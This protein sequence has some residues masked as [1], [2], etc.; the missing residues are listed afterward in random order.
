LPP[1]GGDAALD[2]HFQ[3]RARLVAALRANQSPWEVQAAFREL[4]S[5]QVMERVGIYTDAEAWISDVLR[6]NGGPSA[7]LELAIAHFGWE[8]RR[9]V[10]KD[11]GAEMLALREFLKQEAEAGAFLA[12]LRD[13][14][15]EFHAALKEA[16]RPRTWSGNLLSFPKMELMRRFLDYV[17]DKAPHAENELD[18]QTVAWWRKRIRFWSRP[19]WMAGIVFRGVVIAFIVAMFAAGADSK[20]MGVAEARRRCTAA[21]ENVASGDAPCRRALELAPDSLLMRQYAGI[22]ALR[23]GDFARARS[24]FEQI[25]SLSPLDPVARY[26]LGLAHIG[27]LD[28]AR[29]QTLASQALGMD[30]RVLDYMRERGVVETWFGPAAIAEPP[31]QRWSPGIDTPPSYHADQALFDEA[32][33]HFGIDEP[34]EGGHVLVECLAR[35]W[36][37]VTDCIIIGETPR[38]TGRGEIALRISGAMQ[39]TAGALNGQ[40]VDGVPLRV[41]WRF[42]VRDAI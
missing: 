7:L 18:W 31:G 41:K 14:R 4:T 20:L 33:L 35:S 17:Q 38:N 1:R 30:R 5:G 28:R 19:M 16:T 3:A 40:A 36:G 32:Y 8:Q 13:K 26:G 12:R 21:V 25:A 10:H 6:R 9:L 29:G 11:L 2:E 22:V 27:R 15:H 34:Y 39:V 24:H 37:R 42:S 23:E